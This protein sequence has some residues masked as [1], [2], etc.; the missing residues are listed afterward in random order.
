MQRGL[1]ITFEGSEGCGKSTQISRL[2]ER[3][4]KSGVPLLL[5]REPGGTPVGEE[6][7]HLL[8]FSKSNSA[9]KPETE[10]LLFTASR[11]QIV[12][13]LIEPALAGG[14]TVIADR[15]M[16][17]TTVYQGVARKID[18]GTVRLINQFAVGSCRPDLTFVLDLDG[19]IARE[20]LLKRPNPA[21]VKDRMEQ[22]PDAFYE[23]VRAGYLRLAASEPERIR[24]IDAAGSIEEIEAAIWNGVDA[25]WKQRN[26]R[27]NEEPGDWGAR[28]ESGSPIP[29]P[30]GPPRAGLPAS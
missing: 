25:L 7:R 24:V 1:F 15:F 2:A 9:M 11:A 10:L 21:G 8:Q 28:S 4:K 23:Q 18:A 27:K 19:G 22:E 30:A 29:H 14:K 20:R 26:N 6:I 16:D 12:R 13:E 17:S 3:L 5:T